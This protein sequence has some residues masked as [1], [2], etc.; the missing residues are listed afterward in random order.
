MNAEPTDETPKSALRAVV[1][2]TSMAEPSRSRVL[3]HLAQELVAC[4]HRWT[5]TMIDLREFDAPNFDDRAI[6]RWPGY[7]RVHRMVSAADAVVMA[8]PVYNWGCSS[9]LKKFIEYVG[10][11]PPD[12][13]LV[14]ALFD[15]V[16]TLLTA[17]GLAESYMAFTNTA[18]SLMLDF[19]CVI[20][21]YNV[22]VSED[23][24]KAPGEL[25]ARSKRRLR[26]SMAV[27]MELGERL[28]K[29]TYSSGWEI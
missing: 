19:K 7:R 18:V 3:A 12:G 2:S 26:K 8:S 6:Y 5:C 17:G 4:D 27:M 21:P 1:I 28:A 16:V 9:E 29:R 20:N 13:S 23:A 25:D 22:H 24:W 15:K 10:S 11:T 14:G